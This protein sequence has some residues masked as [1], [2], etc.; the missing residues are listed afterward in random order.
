MKI[1][2]TQEQWQVVAEA[3][4][5]GI[6]RQRAYAV[7]FLAVGHEDHSKHVSDVADSYSKVLDELVRQFEEQQK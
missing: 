1:Q 3:M 2:L 7:K 4:R 6:C 5:D